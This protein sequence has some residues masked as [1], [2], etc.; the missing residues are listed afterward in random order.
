M[1]A[2]RLSRKIHK[3]VALFLGVQLLLWALSGFYM[4]VV[5]IDI[6]HGDMLVENMQPEVRYDDRVHVP[7]ERLATL[8]ADAR[9]ISL[10]SMMGRAVYL[11]EG[12]S[13]RLLDA[14]DGRL[15]SPIDQQTAI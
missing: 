11:V 7:L 3:W 4:V 5:H 12:D 10:K 15:L 9:S 1:R 8:N 2:I 14:F 6:I 13:I